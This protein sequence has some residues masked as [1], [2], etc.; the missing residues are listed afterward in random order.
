[1]IAQYIS[2][3]SRVWGPRTHIKSWEVDPRH[4]WEYADYVDKFN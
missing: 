4:P 3:I 1:M 2:M